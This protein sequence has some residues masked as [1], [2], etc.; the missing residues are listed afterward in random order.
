MKIKEIPLTAFTE[1]G[2]SVEDLHIIDL[3][4]NI[5]GNVTITERNGEHYLFIPPDMDSMKWK[6]WLQTSAGI[7]SKDFLAWLREKADPKYVMIKSATYKTAIRLI[8][9]EELETFESLKL[10][11]GKIHDRY[12]MHLKT[13]GINQNIHG[14]ERYIKEKKEVNSDINEKETEDDVNSSYHSKSLFK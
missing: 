10:I 2:H 4:P 7:F 8:D 1:K 9:E 13:V 6:K 12:Y 14:H 11:N 3:I 5:M